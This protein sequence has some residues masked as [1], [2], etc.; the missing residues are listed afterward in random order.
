MTAANPDQLMTEDQAADMICYS[1]RALQ[2][3]RLRGGGPKYVKVS[4]RSIRYQR[5]DILEW[6]EARKRLHSAD[7]GFG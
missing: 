5:R 4:A 7:G 3:W 6:I 2:N 1:K